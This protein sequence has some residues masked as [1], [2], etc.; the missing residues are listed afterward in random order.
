MDRIFCSYVLQQVAT[1]NLCL[2][3]L[4]L[5]LDIVPYLTSYVIVISSIVSLMRSPVQNLKS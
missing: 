2:K 1:K 3:F 4:H 5:H